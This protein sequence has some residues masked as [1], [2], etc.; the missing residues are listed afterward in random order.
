MF[1]PSLHTPQGL[2]PHFVFCG[3][4]STFRLAGQKR[5]T[6][7]WL[8]LRSCEI[9]IPL[10]IFHCFYTEKKFNICLTKNRPLRHIFTELKIFQN[11]TKN[12]DKNTVFSPTLHNTHA[13]F[14]ETA[15]SK[16]SETIRYRELKAN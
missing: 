4:D 15:Q 6:Y 10:Q 13:S 9:I 16:P 3:V 8:L 12:Y 2:T 5:M 1:D 14:C 7:F 11:K